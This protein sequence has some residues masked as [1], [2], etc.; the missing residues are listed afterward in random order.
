MPVW[1]IFALLVCRGLTDT[2]FGRFPAFFFTHISIYVL[3]RLGRQFFQLFNKLHSAR[4]ITAI[5]Y[6]KKEY[7]VY[8]VKEKYDL[9]CLSQTMLLSSYRTTAHTNGIDVST[10]NIK[11]MYPETVFLNFNGGPEINSKPLI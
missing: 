6:L 3:I 2:S 10:E 5:S 8:S 4:K 9:S 7:T 11:A 1:R